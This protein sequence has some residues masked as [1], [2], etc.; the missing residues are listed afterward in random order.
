[1]GRGWR[2][3]AGRN[4]AGGVSVASETP[5]S[6]MILL[7]APFSAPRVALGAR[8]SPRRGPKQ[9]PGPPRA[10]QPPPLFAGRHDQPRHATRYPLGWG[11]RGLRRRSSAG[12]SD[13]PRHGQALSA[14]LGKR[15]SSGRRPGQLAPSGA[16]LGP[17]TTL[18]L[19]RQ[20]P[21]RRRS[22]AGQGGAPGAKRGRTT[23]TR[24]AETATLARRG[25]EPPA[26]APAPGPPASRRQAPG[27]L[28]NPPGAHPRPVTQSNASATPLTAGTPR[29]PG[30]RRTTTTG[31]PSRPAASIFGQV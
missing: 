19:L 16:V 10:P 14:G 22:A 18:P 3:C 17:E 7:L 31:T 21:T 15:G 2:S 8:S 4:R 6:P 26:P 12:V 24:E 20:P 30:G 13:R 23:L 11:N 1:M 25:R 9:A 27:V 29:G 28:G 5:R